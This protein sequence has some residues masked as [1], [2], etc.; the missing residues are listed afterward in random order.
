M[1]AHRGQTL[2]GKR[3]LVSGSGNVAQYT[4]EKL[5]D[6]GAKPITLSDSGGFITDEAGIDRQKLPYVLELKNVR[7]GRI[8]QYPHRLEGATYTPHPGGGANP[9]WDVTAHCALPSATQN[10]ISRHDAADL[11]KNSVNVLSEAA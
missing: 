7:R 3:C 6:L 5:V 11:L 10:E 9:L 8:A 4:V 2:A 1:L